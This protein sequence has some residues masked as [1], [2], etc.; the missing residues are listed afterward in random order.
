[1]KTQDFSN[2]VNASR[3]NE[4]GQAVIRFVFHHRAVVDATVAAPSYVTQYP[5]C[6]LDNEKKGLARVTCNLILRVR[7]SDDLS[8]FRYLIPFVFRVMLHFHSKENL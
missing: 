6:V 2:L 5:R 4:R 7:N 8:F 3:Q 1:M